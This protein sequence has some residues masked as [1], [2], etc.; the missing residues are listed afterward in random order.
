M[1][2]FSKPVTSVILGGGWRGMVYSSFQEY[3]PERWKVVGVAEPREWNRDFFRTT[4]NIPGQNVYT[5]WRELIDLPQLAD[6]AVI[7]TMDDMHVGPVEELAKKGYAILLEKPMAPDEAGCLRIAKAIKGSGCIFGVCHLMRY[8]LATRMLR[9]IIDSGEIGEIINIQ[10]LENVGYWHQGHAFV[11][12]NWRNQHTSSFM[13][14]SKS[15]H[16]LD[17]LRFM[18]G[19][20][21][22]SVSSFGDLTYFKKSQKP[23]EAGDAERCTD[24]AY[25]P[26]CPY[27]AVKLYIRMCIDV[28]NRQWPVIMVTAETTV[29]GVMEALQTGPYGRCVFECDN[30]VVDH[31]VVN[32][33]F[34]GNRT[35]SFTMTAFNKSDHRKTR[36][37]GT[38]GDLYCDG[39]KIEHF[40]FLTDRLITTDIPPDIGGH[41]GA[42]YRF[43]LAYTEAVAKA[44]QSFINTGIDETLES[45][46]MVFAAEKARL[47]KRVVDVGYQ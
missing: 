23:Q 43:M 13:L 11:R 2:P 34:E 46:I 40:D 45:H 9:E 6:V 24:C 44:N 7:T 18:M 12:G 10:H 31:Q 5:D 26:K 36:I 3:H 33:L 30:N 41:G 21:C 22:L 47:E 17:W 20:R 37:F 1:D 32:M 14:M 15:C 29:G 4:Y 28:G 16:D 27:S 42:D 39:H 8:N 25:E 19:R 35:A 38:L